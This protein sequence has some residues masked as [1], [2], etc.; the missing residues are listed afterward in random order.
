MSLNVCLP[1]CLI[2]CTCQYLV[3]DLSLSVCV[4]VFSCVCLYEFVLVCMCVC[5]CRFIV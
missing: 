3:S 5:L 1:V 4:C 2:L